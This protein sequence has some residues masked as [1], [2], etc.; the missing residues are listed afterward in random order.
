[1]K[2]LYQRLSKENQDKVNN[3]ELR[4][5]KKIILEA[6]SKNYWLDL[7]LNEALYITNCLELETLHYTLIDNLFKHEN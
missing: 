3:Y 6:L 1:M 7:T 2:T 5:S 4:I